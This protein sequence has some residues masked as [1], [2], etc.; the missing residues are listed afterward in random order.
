VDRALGAEP[1]ASDASP[2]LR[3]S[4]R[5]T[6]AELERG[7]VLRVLEAQQW[8]MTAAAEQLGLERSH[9]YKKLRALGI[10]RPE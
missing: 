5:E 9:L 8:R 10:E 6:M 2:V 4:L 1:L 7:V 3:R